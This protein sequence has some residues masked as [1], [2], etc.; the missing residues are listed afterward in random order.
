MRLSVAHRSRPKQG[1]VANGDAALVREEGGHTLVAV[2]DALGHGPMAAQAAAEAVRCLSS[3]PLGTSVEPLV[4]AL[5]AALRGGR[6]AAVMLGL[7]DGK[8]GGGDLASTAHVA[9]L[10]DAPVVLVVDARAMARSAAAMV[11]GYATFDP[12]LRLA[13]VVLNR[14]GSA[15]HEGL[16]RRGEKGGY[17]PPFPC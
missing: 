13:G 11:H 9:K 10:L 5:H 3:L 4:E 17:F 14:V 15:A 1:E 2:V 12:D 7:F 16:L 8:S 6:G